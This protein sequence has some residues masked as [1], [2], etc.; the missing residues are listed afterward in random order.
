VPERQDVDHAA[1]ADALRRSRRGGDQQIG[2]GDRRRRLQMMFEEPDLIDA[3]TFRQLDFFELAPEHFRMCRIFARGR[4][5]P[6]CES[7]PPPSRFKRWRA[8][9][10]QS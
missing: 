1:E 10:Q 8:A 3:D 4:G 6:D 9:R 5:R 2:R 7:H